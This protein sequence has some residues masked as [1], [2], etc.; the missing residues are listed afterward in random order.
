LSLFNLISGIGF[1]F[2]DSSS[3][4]SVGEPPNMPVY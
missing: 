3:L 4:L 2:D 1:F